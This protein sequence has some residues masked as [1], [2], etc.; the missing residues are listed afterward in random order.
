MPEISFLRFAYHPYVQLPLPPPILDIIQSP[1]IFA[2][3]SYIYS[4]PLSQPPTRHCA[5]PTTPLLPNLRTTPFLSSNLLSISPPLT[6]F[7][8]L[9]SSTF[10]SVTTSKNCLPSPPVFPI[11]V[12]SLSASS[13]NLYR[14]VNNDTAGF[15]LPP[16]ARDWDCEG[17]IVCAGLE[18]EGMK[19]DE[20]EGS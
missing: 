7:S 9:N 20:R 3:L 15:I 2:L 17:K 1:I 10:R 14:A 12:N 19:E 4:P 5:T 6:P 16:C 13:A 11:L 18:A 8:S